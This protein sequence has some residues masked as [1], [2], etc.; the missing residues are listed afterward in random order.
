MPHALY[1]Q[2]GRI[3]VIALA[4]IFPAL[5]P[6]RPI[7]DAIPSKAHMAFWVDDID[8]AKA[9]LEENGFYQLL[10]DE[11]TGVA[12]GTNAIRQTVGR[13]PISP[14]DPLYSFW[15][16]LLPIVDS[17]LRESIASATSVFQFT[18]K[19][20]ADT[21]S[22]SAALY[23]TLYDLYVDNETEIVEWDVI[24]AADYQPGER[25]Q[26]DRFLE[27][28][29]ARVP[30]DARKSKVSYFGHDV[31]H[32]T[33][34]LDEQAA[35]PGSKKDNLDL[36]LV[37][38]IPVIVEYAFVDGIFLMAEGR[39]EPLKRVV[40]A[41]GGQ[42]KALRLDSEPRYR[43]ALALLGNEPGRFNFYLDI[44][45]YIRE[46]EDTPSQHSSKRLLHAIGL[47]ESGPF[48]ARIA[49]DKN[50]TRLAAAVLARQTP[51]GV[52]K[53]LAN[54]PDNH[55]ERLKLAPSDAHMAGT[56]SLDFA[57]LYDQY[58][59]AMLVLDAR[60]QGFFDAA[61]KAVEG[62]TGVDIR[63]DVMAAASGEFLSYTRP[64]PTIKN[65]DDIAFVVPL[66]GGKEPVDAINTI[67]KHLTGD[68]TRL[69]DLDP[70]DYQGYTLWE[71]PDAATGPRA[72]TYI[73]AT[74][75]GLALTT[76]G[77][78]LR[79]IIR[80]LS[81]PGSESIMRDKELSDI[82]SR[83]DT[84]NLR[85]FVYIPSKAVARG[86]K[87]HVRLQVS[88]TDTVENLNPEGKA[89]AA[90]WSL[91]SMNGSLLFHYAIEAPGAQ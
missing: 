44:D 90:W 70:S 77:A 55:L 53:L 33:Y 11:R 89:G 7:T 30:G 61:I 24:L 36:G 49:A 15:S 82:L 19:D 38:E 43:Q 66:N 75:R 17:T 76:S 40:R 37:K 12:T 22:G 29:L 13:L 6:A 87:R 35:L 56:L 26:I 1:R 28:A 68:Q 50:G 14:A 34:F 42:G 16:T 65:R 54:S 4:A 86:Y 5:A 59:Q 46:M 88:G 81:S 84:N 71:T 21:F 39:G 9:G 52:Y 45:H 74:P 18:V 32:I 58:R 73:A 57:R 63:N 69:L 10:T 41:L 78:G 62:F 48:I 72:G 27:K 91:H 83:I 8:A 2:T 3:L 23:S 80:S 79:E 67:L 64:A 85:G 20:L 25:Q 60:G 47:D 51:K 31:Y